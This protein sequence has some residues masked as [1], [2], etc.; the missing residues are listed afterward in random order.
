MKWLVPE[1]LLLFCLPINWKEFFSF[2]TFESDHY[3]VCPV[4]VIVTCLEE[5]QNNCPI[6]YKQALSGNKYTF[7][8]IG[9]SL[10]VIIVILLHYIFLEASHHISAQDA[11]SCGSISKI[12]VIYTLSDFPLIW[13][14]VCFFVIKDQVTYMIIDP[15]SLPSNTMIFFFFFF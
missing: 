2:H 10:F 5:K 1:C 15:Q 7:C 8:F 9:K 14:L 12:Q 13:F 3:V 11:G 6:L 4:H